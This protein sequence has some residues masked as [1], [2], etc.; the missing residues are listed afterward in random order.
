MRV[1]EPHARTPAEFSG[2]NAFGGDEGDVGG[3]RLER[4]AVGGDHVLLPYR[5]RLV[6]GVG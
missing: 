6:G 5:T 4:L 1:Q 3:G 2:R